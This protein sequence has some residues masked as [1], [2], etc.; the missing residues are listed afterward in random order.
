MEEEKRGSSESEEEDKRM[1]FDEE[2]EEESESDAF[3]Q[4]PAQQ[5]AQSEKPQDEDPRI[6]QVF[7]F[8]SQ[9]LIFGRMASWEKIKLNLITCALCVVAA[10]RN[11]PA[12]Q[13][14]QRLRMNEDDDPNEDMNQGRARARSLSDASKIDNL[15]DFKLINSNFEGLP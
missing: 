10:T 14:A 11:A 3:S 8:M 1:D 12:A 4:R 6:D 5:M 2:G 7:F 15:T 9:A 13:A